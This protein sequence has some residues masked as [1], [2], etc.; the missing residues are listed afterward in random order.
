MDIQTLLAVA[1]F[2]YVM[3]GVLILVAA[4]PGDQNLTL[5]WIGAAFALGG[6]ALGVAWSHDLLGD[7]SAVRWSNALLL[8][9]YGLL[10]AGLR[11]FTRRPT[12]WWLLLA[13]AAVWLGLC[14]WPSFITAVD[15]RTAVFSALMLVY[16]V[17]AMWVLWPLAHEDRRAVWPVLVF[18]GAHALFYLYRALPASGQGISWLTRPSVSVTIFEN[19]L[20]V[21]GF[22]FSVL[23]MV[24]AS[25]QRWFRHAS[26][27]DAL[28]GLPNRRALLLEGERLWQR[29]RSEGA[30][31][32]VLL[33][34]LDFFKQVNDRHGHATGDRLLQAFA[35]TLKET[36]RPD[37]LCAR[38]GG[39]EFVVLA[40]GADLASARSMGNR[41]RLAFAERARGMALEQTVSVGITAVLDSDQE[42]DR[43]MARADR[44]LYEAKHGGRNRVVVTP[45]PRTEG[46][47]VAACATNA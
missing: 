35:Q 34:D 8:V 36:V 25:E 39:E 3:V 7:G 1:A 41:I 44:A 12:P 24:R 33:C 31:M 2:I 6:V 43:A 19:I 17:A 10:F 28:T 26:L 47:A 40:P 4:L 30:D 29:C 32:A 45:D 37:D 46:A 42:L 18:L 15:L 38:F 5:S 20:F 9:G 27:H 23:T 16:V 11:H 21:V 13:G 22:G 14:L